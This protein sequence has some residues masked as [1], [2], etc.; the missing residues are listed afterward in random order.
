[1][2]ESKF[3][4]IHIPAEHQSAPKEHWADRE[5][6]E[7]AR[8]IDEAKWVPDTG[9]E[10]REAAEGLGLALGLGNQAAAL[11]EKPALGDF[12]D[13][14]EQNKILDSIAQHPRVAE[15]LERMRKEVA[16]APDSHEL[17]ERNAMLREMVEASERKNRWDGQGRWLGHEN[18]EMRY[19]LILTPTQFYERLEKVIGTDRVVLS[20]HVFFAHLGAKSGISG[21]FVR[22]PRWNGAQ[23]I[24]REGARAEA[25]RLEKK[26]RKHW[27]KARQLRQLGKDASADREFNIAAGCAQDAAKILMTASAEAQLG[28]P[29][30]LRVGTMQWPLGTE[31]MVMAFTEWGTVYKPKFYGWRTALLTMMRA[32]AITEAEA[33]RA[34]PVDPGPA[35]DWYLQQIYE[36]NLM[37]GVVLQ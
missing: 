25:G 17:V 31:W 18:E 33:H 8:E 32:K 5:I 3:P 29:E 24:Y 34:F 4:A 26:G 11:G 23:E 36:M 7:A 12:Q 30:Y 10:Q 35:G 15:A 6:K 37:G 14:Y 27:M 28:E 21:L 2:S 20:E 16:D 13:T 1:M 19:G 22:N 9:D